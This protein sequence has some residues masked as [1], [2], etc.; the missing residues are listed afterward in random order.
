MQYYKNKYY[1]KLR[2]ILIDIGY[3]DEILKYNIQEHLDLIKGINRN[4]MDYR[5][6]PIYIND[7]LKYFIFDVKIYLDSTHRYYLELDK[8]N[9]DILSYDDLDLLLKA[10]LNIIREIVD[11]SYLTLKNKLESGL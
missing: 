10:G 11:Y 2:N 6:S 4:L 7:K 3:Y 9:F 5:F 1:D 8:N